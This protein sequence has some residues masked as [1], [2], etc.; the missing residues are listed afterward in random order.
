VEH[1]G[2]LLLPALLH[3][4]KGFLRRQ[5][6]LGA[7]DALQLLEYLLETRSL[8]WIRLP[9]ACGLVFLYCESHKEVQALGAL[10]TFHQGSPGL[11]AGFWYGQGQ[12]VDSHAIGHG[13]RIEALVGRLAR[14]QFPQ[15]YTIAPN[16][17]G[18]GR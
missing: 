10:L 12:R 8:V 2:D 9:A 14:N 4:V 18:S 7:R 5:G 11:W 1:F 16:I 3:I 13:Q 15:Q 17:R 6:E